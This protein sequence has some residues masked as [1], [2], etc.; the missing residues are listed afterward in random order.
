MIES[1]PNISEGRRPAVVDR[2]AGAVAAIPGV[3]L[4]D[5]TSD[6]SHNR[7][8][9]TFAGDAAS[10]RDAIVS[11]FAAAIP[12]IDLRGHSGVHPRIGAVDVVPFVPLTA[13]TLDDCVALARQTGQLVADRFAIPVFLYEAAATRPERRRLEQIRRGQFEGLAMKM[14]GDD[15]RPDFGPS[16]PHPTAGAT[17]I[18]ARIP[19]IAYN[20][21]LASSRLAVA[22]AIARE[23]RESNG[24]L[25]GVKALGVLLEDR[26]VAQVSMNLT[27]YLVTGIRTV[28]DAV[29]LLA[30]RQGVAVLESELIGLAPAAALDAATAAH[31]RLR[32]SPDQ[33][34]ENR[35]QSAW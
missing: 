2:L 32:F 29:A 1:I 17:V 9:L 19:L 18:G 12:A 33:I 21:N 10:V 20:I 28:F 30:A 16:H 23:V 4:L 22:Q 35:L 5:R 24:G 6:P 31:V 34:L 25:P 27:D 3:R 26:Q 14:A 15:W 7:S 11:L 8:V 13:A